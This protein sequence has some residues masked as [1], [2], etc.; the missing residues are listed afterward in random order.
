MEPIIDLPD[1]SDLDADGDF[2]LVKVD[3]ES[4]GKDI[5]SIETY[6]RAEWLDETEN[7]LVWRLIAQQ[8]SE[9]GEVAP[10]DGQALV[11]AELFGWWVENEHS[12]A[13]PTD[14]TWYRSYGDVYGKDLVPAILD[15]EWSEGR[16][17]WSFPSIRHKDKGWLQPGKYGTGGPK[18]V[19]P[20]IFGVGQPKQIDAVE[21]RWK[22]ASDAADLMG[23]EVEYDWEAAI[24][25]ARERFKKRDA[26]RDEELD[27]SA[28]KSLED[29][30]N[31]AHVAASKGFV[32]FKTELE[33]QLGT[34]ADPVTLTAASEA[35]AEAVRQV[36]DLDDPRGDE[37]DG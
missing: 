5:E 37:D 26:W 6:D 1:G 16:A 36:K 22:D 11:C 35:V 31:G 10:D 3:F 17:A 4:G 33:E 30:H 15:V 7:D 25:R 32:T 9:D 24:E 12:D 28:M 14:T 23:G 18:S 19:M 20:V 21:V 13:D 27:I 8:E 2:R 34:E 29:Q